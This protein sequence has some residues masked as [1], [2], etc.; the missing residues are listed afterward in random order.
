[1]CKLRVARRRTADDGPEMDTKSETP[2]SDDVIGGEVRWS[3]GKMEAAAGDV[4]CRLEPRDLWDKFHA[5]GTEMII[6]K[7]G[8]S[9]ARRPLYRPWST[10][11]GDHALCGSGHAVGLLCVCVTVCVC[12]SPCSHDNAEAN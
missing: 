3:A 4:A 10:M 12:V 2:T 1:M 8:R 9:V 5:L 6:T 11:V 7:S